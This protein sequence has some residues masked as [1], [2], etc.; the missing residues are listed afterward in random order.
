MKWETQW[1]KK[2]MESRLKEFEYLNLFYFYFLRVIKK[3]KY[4]DSVCVLFWSI[5][6]TLISTATLIYFVTY[7]PSGEDI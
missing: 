1:F 5:T 2:T 3:Y 6:N 4:L 7:S